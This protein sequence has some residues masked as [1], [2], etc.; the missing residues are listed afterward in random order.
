MG[1]LSG[2]RRPVLNISSLS[3]SASRDEAD[4]GSSPETPAVREETPSAPD[5]LDEEV[6]KEEESTDAS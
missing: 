3:A 4:Q 1:S 2:G 6:E 5:Q